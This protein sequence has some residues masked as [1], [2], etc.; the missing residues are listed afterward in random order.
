[1]DL[2]DY[3]RHALG[4]RADLRARLCLQLSGALWLLCGAERPARMSDRNI[5]QFL[6]LVVIT[7]GCDPACRGCSGAGDS[8]CDQCAANYSR[9]EGR[10]RL[11]SPPSPP[12]PPSSP[13][14][15]YTSEEKKNETV[16]DPPSV[17]NNSS[18]E[19]DPTLVQTLTG[20][21]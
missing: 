14:S 10:C 17:E 4:L 2:R 19:V 18:S 9:S 20:G 5:Q 8:A 21:K 16:P 12:P 15:N 3:P 7:I 11:P 1:M 13:S 6:Y